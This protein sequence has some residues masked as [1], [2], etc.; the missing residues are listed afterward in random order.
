MGGGNCAQCGCPGMAASRGAGSGGG[1]GDAGGRGEPSGAE[2]RAAGTP[3]RGAKVIPKSGAQVGWQR[4]REGAGRVWPARKG[5]RMTGAGARGCTSDAQ[6]GGRLPRD[7]KLG[8][9]MST[10]GGRGL[11]EPMAP[12]LASRW[13]GMADLFEQTA[14][15]GRES[16]PGIEGRSSSGRKNG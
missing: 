11:G 15:P 7:P 4:R 6:T 8:R 3:R 12:G 5:L 13:V 1:G 14:R 10:A 9:P 16:R 2:V